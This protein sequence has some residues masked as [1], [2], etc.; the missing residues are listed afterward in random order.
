MTNS[1]LII[2]DDPQFRSAF[3]NAVCSANDLYLA[4]TADDLMEGLYLLEKTK[5]DVLLVDI[6]LP[7]GSGIDLIRY[8]NVNLPA[9][10]VMVVT[11]FGD[12]HHVLECI[13]AGATGYLLKD[14]KAI[15]I[16]EQIRALRMGG[17]PISPVIAR[18]LMKR[19]TAKPSVTSD[20]QHIALST[21]ERAVLEM[22]SKGYSYKEIA[23][24]LQLSPSTV[25][26]YVKRLYRKLSVHSKNEAVYEA[27]KQGWL[28]D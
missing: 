8:A 26:T 3:A 6:G 11:V 12:E 2:E 22:S 24:L 27:R 10:D 23:S 7:S 28:R 25:G 16:V 20:E 1:V 19:F 4:G 14:S 5:P 15:N 17:S 21:Q 13:E 9:C 18:Q